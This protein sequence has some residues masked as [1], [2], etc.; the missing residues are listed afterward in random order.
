M[1]Y[2]LEEFKKGKYYLCA[3][4][5]HGIQIMVAFS[6]YTSLAALFDVGPPDTCRIAAQ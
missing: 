3:I 6:Y 1:K 4:R 5:G 2:V